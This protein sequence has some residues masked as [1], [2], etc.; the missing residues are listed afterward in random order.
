MKKHLFLTGESGLGK[1]T[2]IRQALGDKLAYAGGLVT[3]RVFGV[4]GDVLGYDLL[5]AAA[6]YSRTGYDSWRII[7]YVDGKPVK[8]NE[9]FRNQG[10]RL[11]QESSY[12]PYVLLDEIGGFEM[13]IPQFRNALAEVLNNDVPIIG[14]LK[15]ANNAAAVKERFGLGYKF[16]MLTDNLR[17]VLNNDS[18]TVVLEVKSLGDPVAQRIVQSWVNEYVR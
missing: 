3:E 17:S 18:D 1:T 2:L 4:G 11:L 8:D 13:L 16:T 12:Y 14:V 9:I 15:S 10:V 5:P 6:A 7:N